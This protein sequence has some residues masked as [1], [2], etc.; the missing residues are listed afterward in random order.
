[1]A[2][3]L[4]NLALLYYA[5]GR[6]QEAEP[7]YVEALKIRRRFQRNYSPDVAATLNNLALLYYAQGRYQEAEPLY[8]EA[9]Q[10]RKSILGIITLMWR[11]HSII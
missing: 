6:Y 9:L 3:T 2:T 1:V 8:M 4:N 11:Q 10:L 5:Q 7:L